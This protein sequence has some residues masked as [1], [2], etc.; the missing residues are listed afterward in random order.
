MDENTKIDID[1][2]LKEYEKSKKNKDGISDYV[3]NKKRF[4]LF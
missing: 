2:L 3:K 4:W 1:N